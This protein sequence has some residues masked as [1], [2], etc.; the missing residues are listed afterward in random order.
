MKNNK[1]VSN[2]QNVFLFVCF[3]FHFVP[4][5]SDEL[6]QHRPTFLDVASGAPSA[7]LDLPQ[8]Y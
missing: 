7:F 3:K 5:V 2:G 4:L 8:W 6:Q 1:S